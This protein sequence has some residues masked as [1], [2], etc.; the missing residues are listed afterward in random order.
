MD[1]VPLM[2]E[3]YAAFFAD[4]KPVSTGLLY[5]FQ[6]LAW[7]ANFCP[8]DSASYRGWM[9]LIMTSFGLLG[10]SLCLCEGVGT[11]H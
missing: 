8:I 2:N 11:G 7:K 6:V 10:K 5:P 4:P 9:K 1:D 3:A